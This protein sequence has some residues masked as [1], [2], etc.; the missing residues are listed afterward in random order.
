MLA[1]EY[2][3][4]RHIVEQPS[5]SSCNQRCYIAL[6]AVRLHVARRKESRNETARQE[7]TDVE[8]WRGGLDPFCLLQR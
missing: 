7:H 2:V 6:D 4:M 1:R 3:A 5:G 8:E